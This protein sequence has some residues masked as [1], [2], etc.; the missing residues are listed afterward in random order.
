MPL[1]EYRDFTRE[2]DHYPDTLERS[3]KIVLHTLGLVGEAGEVANKVKKI[4]RDD[5]GFL[6]EKMRLAL[7]KEMGGTL[8]YYIRVLDDLGVDIGEIAQLNREEL[9][10][11]VARGTLLGSG[12]DR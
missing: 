8:W 1:E 7:C 4:I 12:D 6:T 9:E 3:G 11:R 5:K 10:S 2:L